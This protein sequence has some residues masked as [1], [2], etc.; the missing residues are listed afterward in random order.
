MPPYKPN[1]DNISGTIAGTII[2][3]RKKRMIGRA[4]MPA[5]DLILVPKR[6]DMAA[7]ASERMKL[8]NMIYR[9]N[10]KGE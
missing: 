4:T 8:E 9:M 6:K 3:R 10:V 5:G 1:N 7:I 2:R